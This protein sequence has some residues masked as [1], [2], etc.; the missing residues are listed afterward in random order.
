MAESVRN[1][2][3]RPEDAAGRAL[4][5]RLAQLLDAARGTPEESALFN[6]LAPKYLAV[7]TALGL[8][9]AGRGTKGGG[10]DGPGTGDPVIDEIRAKRE[11]RRSRA[12]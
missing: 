12:D 6:D 4:A 5:R 10:Q 7:L 1:A 3:N 9:L 8:T 11:R 2:P